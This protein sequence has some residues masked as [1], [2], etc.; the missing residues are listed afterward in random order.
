VGKLEVQVATRLAP[1][2]LVAALSRQLADVATVSGGAVQG[3]RVDLQ[4][5]L[6]GPP[7][8]VPGAAPPGA[9]VP[10]PPPPP[11]PPVPARAP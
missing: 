10:P 3:S 1:A 2:A 4:V 7:A 11:P 8:T 9:G 5:R 6:G